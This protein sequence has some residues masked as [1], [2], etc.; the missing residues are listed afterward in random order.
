MDKFVLYL[1]TKNGKHDVVSELSLF[2]SQIGIEDI[3]MSEDIPCV[4]ADM[5]YSELILECPNSDE[6]E[7]AELFV[8]KNSC[9]TM[10]GKDKDIIA[11]N[12]LSVNCSSARF[13]QIFV[14]CYGFVQFNI[15]LTFKSGETLRL[16][17][18]HL[19]VYFKD[20]EENRSLQKMAEFIYDNYEKYLYDERVKPDNQAGLKESEEF[21][22]FEIYIEK[23]KKIIIAY[24]TCFAYFKINPRFK[25][26]EIG[27]IDNFE[28]LKVISN[29]TLT[30]IVQHPE[31]LLPFEGNAGIKFNHR[32]YQPYKTLVKDNVLNYD[33]PEN[34][35]VIGF[36]K[37]LL[38]D[39]NALIEKI[40]QLKGKLSKQNN[41]VLGYISSVVLLIGG[42]LKRLNRYEH[43]IRVIKDNILRLN[44]AY[45]EIFN[46]NCET[47]TYIPEPTA[48]F[49]SVPQY[50]VI[51]NLIVQWFHFGKYDLKKE[52]FILPFLVNHQLFEYYV[53]LKL[54]TFFNE[55]KSFNLHST[56]KFNYSVGAAMYKNTTY[57][58]TFVF[59]T[60]DGGITVYYQPVIFGQKYDST[61]NNGIQLFRNT[62]VRVAQDYESEN[63]SSSRNSYY[64]PDYIIKISASDKSKYIILDAKYMTVD[65]FKAYH[66]SNLV[67]KYLYS[68]SAV[69]DKDCIAGMCVICGKSNSVV[70][71]FTAKDI[72][73]L[74]SISQRMP[75]SDIMVLHEK[76]YGEQQIP[77]NEIINRA[78]SKYLE[79]N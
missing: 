79:N 52:E 33:I 57:N 7:S 30:Y 36:L 38:A 21:K 34:R 75:Y 67:F 60:D 35:A 17:S 22:S 27:K 12:L 14:D 8:N 70:D 76:L 45:E 37:F 66:L 59:T 42:T 3:L 20:N 63:F 50:N 61:K 43:E 19:A 46:I 48:I 5:I 28:K 44:Y 55:Y 39:T 6:I 25:I 56:F 10:S 47:I 31:E 78:I 15:S 51:Y 11:F 71:V 74:L 68:V 2:N 41:S 9:C 73:E 29:D 18:K 26:T 23:L 62:S 13:G 4:F 77:H 32:Y 64:T 54:L 24:D 53:L 40:I 65:N 49:M 58:N 16:Y 1:K 72:A 69:D